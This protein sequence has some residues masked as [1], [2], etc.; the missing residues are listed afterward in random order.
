MFTIRTI[1]IENGDY[2]QVD[3][4]G[5]NINNSNVGNGRIN[6]KYELKHA[7]WFSK[8]YCSIISGGE[9]RNKRTF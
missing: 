9:S 7:E 2:M 1:E 3:L 8:G 5:A 6:A 4:N